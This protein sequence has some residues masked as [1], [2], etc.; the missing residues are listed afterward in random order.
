MPDASTIDKIKMAKTVYN[1]RPFTTNK[2]SQIKLVVGLAR[3]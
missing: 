2:G 3:D 1:F